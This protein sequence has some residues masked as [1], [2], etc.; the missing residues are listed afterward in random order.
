MRFVPLKTRGKKLIWISGWS[1][2]KLLRFT[3]T[4]RRTIA[5]D[6]PWKEELETRN[7]FQSEN[8]SCYVIGV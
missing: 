2:K 6:K 5:G 4:I 8:G 1:A 3:I 7:G